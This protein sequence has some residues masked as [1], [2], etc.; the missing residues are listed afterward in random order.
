MNNCNYGSIL[1]RFE[2]IYTLKFG[3]SRLISLISID[4]LAQNSI[5]FNSGTY[6]TTICDMV[7]VGLIVS[8]KSPGQTNVQTD[9]NENTIVAMRL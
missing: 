5:G 3:V 1:H 8:E 7:T 2:D 6:S 9:K 4:Y